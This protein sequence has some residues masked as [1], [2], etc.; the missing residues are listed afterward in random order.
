[1]GQMPMIAKYAIIEDG[2]EGESAS[3]SN[4]EESA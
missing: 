2:E 1:L 4:S 3:D